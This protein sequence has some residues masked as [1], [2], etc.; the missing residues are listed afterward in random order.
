MRPRARTVLRLCL[1]TVHG[2]SRLVPSAVRDDWRGTWDAEL[3]HRVLQLDRHGRL[4]VRA[5]AA[6]F[7]RCLGAYWHAAWVLG[8]GLAP[9][10][11]LAGGLIALRELGAAPAATAAAVLSLGLALGLGGTVLGVTQAAQARVGVTGKERVVRLWNRAPAAQIGRTGLSP[12]ELRTFRAQSSSIEALAG[13]RPAVVT[14]GSGESASAMDA[15]LVSP[16]FFETIGVVA[17][18]G[19]TFRASDSGS[20][21]ADA[22]PP[23]V[24]DGQL[25]RERFAG[26][27]GILGRTVVIDGAPHRVVGVVTAG[28]R[29]PRPGTRLWLPLGPVPES[30]GSHALGVVARLRSGVAPETA[31]QE[32]NRLSRRLQADFPGGYLGQ[33]GVVWSVVVEPLGGRG[34][35]MSRLLALLAAGAA[36][37]MAAGVAA[38]SSVSAAR[39]RARPGR[40]RGLQA[41]ATVV[42]GTAIGAL[43]AVS[44]LRALGPWLDG[45][46]PGARSAG[47][48]GEALGLVG[49]GAGVALA[50]HL[51]GML[52]R[53]R[54][55]RAPGRR[56]VPLALA[57]C[58]VALGLAAGI[59]AYGYYGVRGSGSGFRAD[60]LLAVTLGPGRQVTTDWPSLVA[61]VPGVETVSRTMAAPLVQSLNGVT[62]VTDESSKVGQRAPM[63]ADLQVADAAYFSIVGLPL[64]AGRGFLT[65]TGGR[66]NE[67]PQEVVIDASLA[68]RFWPGETPVGRQI[69][70]VLD[71]GH[72]TG[73]LTIVGVAAN[74]YGTAPGELQAPVLYLPL[75][76][77]SA[78]DARTL[79]IRTGLTP[80]ELAAAIR[81]TGAGTVEPVNVAAVLAARAAPHLAA[82]LILLVLAGLV[83][84]IAAAPRIA[85]QPPLQRLTK[86]A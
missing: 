62:F 67:P 63:T 13:L 12:L 53:R 55:T 52:A 56:R 78:A 84:V 54:P 32:L 58:A 14:F 80:A 19:R 74:L 40:A 68:A 77:D 9:R 5:G 49:V 76:L 20:H 47:A 31:E 26:D 37:T 71:P 42:A 39:L 65:S 59:C 75:G 34:P 16:E 2:A 7:H 81:R 35:R 29:M 38:A 4:T 10:A 50:A 70:V 79:L 73:W 36:L 3:W 27:P 25:W 15:G 28:V 60:S 83:I 61:R 82:S 17:E 8:R 45:W 30:P 23:V 1:F 21:R 51:A 46:L 18:I 11:L 64:V 48:G 57:A 66:T 86:S 6:L 41:V 72:V 24:L 43:L 69:R 22:A 33:L 44:A 85:S